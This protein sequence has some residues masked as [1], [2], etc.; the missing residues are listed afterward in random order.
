MARE[1]HKRKSDNKYNIW[2]TVID[3]YIYEWNTKEKLREKLMADAIRDA[4]YKVDRLLYVHDR[5]VD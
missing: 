1:L 4:E 2:S 3:D 5:E